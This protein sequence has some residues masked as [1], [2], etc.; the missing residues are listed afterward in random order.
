MSIKAKFKTNFNV[1]F[2]AKFKGASKGGMGFKS[3]DILI[4]LTIYRNISQCI[5]NV[6]KIP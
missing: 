1:K 4:I 3:D 5:Y 6:L 2:K